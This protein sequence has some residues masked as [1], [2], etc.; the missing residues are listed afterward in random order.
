MSR[1]AFEQAWLARFPQLGKYLAMR[2]GE[3]FI[4]DA[5][6]AWRWFNSGYQAA[7]QWTPYKEGDDVAYD[8]NAL[9]T[10]EFLPLGCNEYGV[11]EAWFRG[12]KWIDNGDEVFE[13]VTAYMP[14][15]EPYVPEVE[16]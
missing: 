10:Y 14:L 1:E 7:E 2:D 16:E 3:Y 11:T 12:G 4:P 9:V 13:H 5:V 8:T 15:P 6:N